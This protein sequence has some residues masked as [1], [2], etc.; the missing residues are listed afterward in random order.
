M[1]A[2]HQLPQIRY[3][4]VS[5]NRLS[6]RRE[7]TGRVSSREIV[8][9]VGRRKI[10][11]KVRSIKFTG[12]VVGRVSSIKFTGRANSR[13]IVERSALKRS[14]VGSA[15]EHRWIYWEVVGCS[16]PPPDVSSNP[17]EKFQPPQ[18]KFLPPPR[19][20]GYSYEKEVLRV[21]QSINSTDFLQKLGL[22]PKLI[23]KLLIQF[24]KYGSNYCT[25]TQPYLNNGFM[26]VVLLVPLQNMCLNKSKN[27]FQECTTTCDCLTQARCRAAALAAKNVH[28]PD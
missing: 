27:E 7:F 25:S 9:R 4:G 14:W 19:L 15:V 11:G 16:P 21:S 20:R 23:I 28:P 17:P 13:E 8:G 18:K 26:M 10:V 6:F 22:Y 5:Y 1:S 2:R 3:L 24:L 12:R